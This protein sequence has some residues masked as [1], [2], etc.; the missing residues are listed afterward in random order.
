VVSSAWH[1]SHLYKR[2]LSKRYATLVDSSASGMRGAPPKECF[3]D[4]LPWTHFVYNAVFAPNTAREACARYHEALLVD[5]LLEVSP[6][7]A[8]AETVTQF[9]LLP[10]Q[11]IGTHL[12]KFFAALMGELSW[13][14]SVIVMPFVFA[15][16]LL[17]MIMWFGYRDGIHQIVCRFLERFWYMCPLLFLVFFQVRRNLEKLVNR[18]GVERNFLLSQMMARRS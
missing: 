16:I 9:V 11:H 7:M 1:W 10:L 18:S 8:I 6:T 17:T 13:T 3:P 14:T 4:Q 5:P 2:A 12:G 15:A